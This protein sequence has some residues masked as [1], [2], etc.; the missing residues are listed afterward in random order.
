AADRAISSKSYQPARDLAAW[1][2]K[3]A[4]AWPNVHVTHVESGGVDVSPQVGEQLQVRAFVQLG[5][6]SPDDVSVEL[7][8]GRAREGDQLVDTG[9][10]TLEL[11]SL[12]G[13]GV[14]NYTG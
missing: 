12:E 10:V 11:D 3:V 1:K 2:A 7:V 14:G 8:H 5:T 13:S 9:T 4:A 6:L